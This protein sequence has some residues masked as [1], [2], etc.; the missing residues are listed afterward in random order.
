M[1]PFHLDSHMVTLRGVFYPTGHIV[2]MLPGRE[3]AEQAAQ[4]LVAAGLPGDEMSLLSPETFMGPIARTI[5]SGD[6]PLPSPGTEGQTVR[7]LVELAG[8][9]HW[10]LLVP[11]PRTS[12]SERVMKAVKELP[13]TFAER[14]R[15]LV[16][17]DL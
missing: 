11:A 8:E 4:A 5:G 1:K 17:E 13:V 10:G 6:M 9:G 16:I 15:H 14:Y 2:L 7:H 3:P 12:D